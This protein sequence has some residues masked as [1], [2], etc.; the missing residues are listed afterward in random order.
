MGT[1]FNAIVASA[2][3]WYPFQ[4]D[5]ADDTVA[6]YSGGGNTATLEGDAARDTTTEVSVSGPNGWLEKAFEFDGSTNYVDVPVSVTSKPFS[7]F[8]WVKHGATNTVI[9]LSDASLSN[10][11]DSLILE[12]SGS[13]VV[14]AVS[15][16]VNQTATSATLAAVGWHFVGAV[17]S[18]T[19]SRKVYLDANA[20]VE[21]TSTQSGVVTNT[22]INI[23]RLS[24]ATPA[25]YY[26]DAIAGVGLLDYA[27]T[28]AEMLQ[29]RLGP[30]L[31]YVSGVSF[32]SDGSYDIGTWALP[33]PFA[34]GSNGSQTQEV[35]AVN[36]V[37][38][39]LDSDTTATGTLDLSSETGNTC[40]LLARV[41][42]TGGYDVGDY[43]TR[44]SG[45]GSAD[46]GYYEIASVTAAGGGGTS[47]PVFAHHYRQLARA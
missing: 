32:A 38:S 12:W 42:N 2:E 36:A 11:Q 44:T 33:S 35:I 1:S 39:V 28:D 37:G 46:D 41:S 40:Y 47:V 24:D 17:F 31:N 27:L 34:S 16:P 45:Y 7:V 20:A 23:G 13:N 29:V 6:D 5:A 4:D 22:A 18:S 10:F 3:G 15:R 25:R 14:D 19:T 8:G 9:S 43:A 21:D 30:E 26:D